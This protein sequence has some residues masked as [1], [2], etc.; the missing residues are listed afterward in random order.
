M[1]PTIRLRTLYRASAWALAAFLLM[2]FLGTAMSRA[3][4]RAPAVVCNASV[5]HPIS[6]RVEALDPVQRGAAVRL[7]VTTESRV[8]LSA[9]DVRLVSA[10]GATLVGRAAVAVG[11]LT[12][13][14][15]D[16]REFAVQV[17]A[18]GQRFLVEFRVS[19]EGPAGRLTRGAAYNLLP[20]GRAVTPRVVTDASGRAI[21]ESPARRIP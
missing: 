5:Q 10:G 11:R 14:R 15:A 12:P 1:F 20:E 4:S 19:G 18:Q 3:E 6:V 13:G 16:V 8:G 21:A 9:A 2:T 17:P 7:R